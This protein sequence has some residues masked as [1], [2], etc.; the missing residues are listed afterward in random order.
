MLQEGCKSCNKQAMNEHNS[1]KLRSKGYNKK[2]VV[3]LDI[4]KYSSDFSGISLH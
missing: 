2:I 3:F 4:L 1:K